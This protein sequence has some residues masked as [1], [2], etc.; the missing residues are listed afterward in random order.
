MDSIQEVARS[1]E[2]A[3]GNNYKV[4]TWTNIVF[5]NNMIIGTFKQFND[6]K[7][8][9]IAVSKDSDDFILAEINE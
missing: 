7:H 8:Y 4:Q 1:L 5:E 2:I 6:P 3:L 9:I